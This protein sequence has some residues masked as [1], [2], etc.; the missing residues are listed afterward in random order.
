MS[1][2]FEL[3]L[4]IVNNG[5]SDDVM[6]IAREVGARGGT[7]INARGT[8]KEEAEKL[9]NITITPEK[10]IVL[11]VVPKDIVDDLLH[12]IYKNLGLN[13]AGGGIAFS[14]PVNEVAGIQS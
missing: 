1:K 7:I 10:E 2:K 6:S 11:T 14:I 5:F 8:A 4:I 3:V 13:T 9:F 12:A